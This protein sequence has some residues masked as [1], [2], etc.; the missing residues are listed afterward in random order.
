MTVNIGGTPRPVPGG[1]LLLRDIEVLATM[2][3]LLG[4]I[5]D[6]AVFVDRNVIKWVGETEDIP[7]EYAS[8]DCVLSLK[9]RVVIPGMVSLR[10]S[11]ASW[12]SSFGDAKQLKIPR[13]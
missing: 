2:N 12:L 5:R 6:A 10:S 11:N 1:T 4:D 9:N 7:P 13:G 8:A 3:D